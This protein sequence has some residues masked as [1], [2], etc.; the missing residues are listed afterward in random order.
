MR[1]AVVLL[2]VVGLA[3]SASACAASPHAAPKLTVPIL[4]GPWA[5][6]Q[7]GY[8]RAEPTT[9]YNGGDALGRVRNIE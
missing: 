9:I 5:S 2:A 8:G 1:R 3:W 7:E 4:A 6:F